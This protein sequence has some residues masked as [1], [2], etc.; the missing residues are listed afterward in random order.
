MREA[1]ASMQVHRT[2]SAYN[3][4]VVLFAALGSIIYGYDSSVIAT[5]LVSKAIRANYS[6]GGVFADNIVTRVS[7]CSTST[8][9]FKAVRHTR[10]KSQEPVTVSLKQEDF[11]AVS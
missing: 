6:K 5:I 2:I 8:S 7:R 10:H 3:I 11:S 9:V 4:A 1:R